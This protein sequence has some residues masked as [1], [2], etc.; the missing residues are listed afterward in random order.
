MTRA[1]MMMHD[2]PRTAVMMLLSVSS[3]APR[4]FALLI[5][6]PSTSWPTMRMFDRLADFR[7]RPM[8]PPMRPTPM[9]TI[10][11]RGV[12]SSIAVSGP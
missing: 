6:R 1:A 11:C 9:M 12:A 2:D 8:D 4:F 3:T 5:A 10:F 7:A